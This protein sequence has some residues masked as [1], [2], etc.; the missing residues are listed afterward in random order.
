[1]P[2]A[3]ST[4]HSHVKRLSRGVWVPR[5]LEKSLNHLSATRIELPYFH[6]RVGIRELAHCQGSS[7]KKRRQDPFG[8]DAE[9]GCDPS[10]GLRLGHVLRVNLLLSHVKAMNLD[11]VVLPGPKA[12]AYH[13]YSCELQYS[14]G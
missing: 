13:Q 7:W 4:F 12:Q 3:V 10:L 11:G 8:R 5:H 9:S 14:V 1:M 2:R 6:A